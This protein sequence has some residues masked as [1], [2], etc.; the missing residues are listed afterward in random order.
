MELPFPD[1]YKLIDLE[2]PNVQY[3]FAVLF[4]RPRKNFFNLKKIL[5]N[6]T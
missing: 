3:S 1:L 6:C 4:S 5:L 2:N